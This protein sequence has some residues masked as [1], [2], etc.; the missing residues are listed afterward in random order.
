MAQKVTVSLQDD[1]DGGPASETVRFALAGTEFEI[2]LSEQNASTFR[3][4]LG[5][6]IEHARKA[7]RATRT[8]SAAR[9]PG[10]RERTADIRAWAR[11]RGI[12]INERGR[13]PA[14]VLEQYEAAAK[15]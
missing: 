5:P 9:G 15:G 4:Q 12:P 10:N 7:G 1:L 13:I 2:D 11:D 3:R 14:S 8:R 6:F